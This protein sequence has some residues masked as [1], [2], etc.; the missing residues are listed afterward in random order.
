[1]VCRFALLKRVIALLTMG[2]GQ[3]LN[4]GAEQLEWLEAN[5]PTL[6]SVDPLSLPLFFLDLRDVGREDSRCLAEPQ[7]MRNVGACALRS[8]TMERTG[9]PVPVLSLY[10]ASAA[11]YRREYGTGRGTNRHGC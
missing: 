6:E 11:P 8:L 3:P 5:A 1:M 9:A 10:G 4:L 2:S 7:F